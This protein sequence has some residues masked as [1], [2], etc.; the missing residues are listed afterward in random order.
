M[1]VNTTINAAR[2][3]ELMTPYKTNNYITIHLSSVMKYTTICKCYI[4]G[5]RVA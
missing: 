2:E 3:N 1:S 5:S 4:L